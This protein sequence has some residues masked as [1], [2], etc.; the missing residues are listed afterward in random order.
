MAIILFFTDILFYAPSVAMAKRWERSYV[1]HFNE[2]NPWEG[3]YTGQASHMLDIA[4]LWQ[5]Y[6]HKLT[7]PQ[8]AVAK[9][10]AENVIAFSAGQEPVPPFNLEQCV[11]VYGPSSRGAT[12]GACQLDDGKETKRR[13]G[14][15]TSATQI[16]GGLDALL[17]AALAF[18]MS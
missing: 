4:Y 9:T 12:F 16:V 11:G 13:A 17:D 18:L 5:N 14:F 10:L 7:A 8:Q 3:I 1:C 6:N 15:F 2:E